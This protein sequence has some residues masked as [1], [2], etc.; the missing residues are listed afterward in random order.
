MSH[1]NVQSNSSQGTKTNSLSTAGSAKQQIMAIYQN[2]KTAESEM[3][4]KL[5]ERLGRPIEGRGDLQGILDGYYSLSSLSADFG[6]NNSPGGV[7]GLGSSKN[8]GLDGNSKID[9]ITAKIT[10]MLADGVNSFDEIGQ[11]MRLVS[12]AGGAV[13][14]QVIAH[15]KDGIKGFLQQQ[16]ETGGG[17]QDALKLLNQIQQM[18]GGSGQTQELIK[19]VESM[20]EAFLEKQEKQMRDEIMTQLSNFAMQKMEKNMDELLGGLEATSGIQIPKSDLST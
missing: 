19:E 20:L 16:L 14:P 15:I 7:M 3:V 10:D 17:A 13:P 18:A 1:P 6:G 5:L 4:S 2:H 11:V 8:A 12:L 9:S